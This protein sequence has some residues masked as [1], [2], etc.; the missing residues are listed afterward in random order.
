MLKTFEVIRDRPDVRGL[1]LGHIGGDVKVAKASVKAQ[2][3]ARATMTATFVSDPNFL[4]GAPDRER[5]AE[6][7]AQA[8]MG[9]VNGLAALGV[10]QNLSPEELTDLLM[11]LL[12]PGIYAIAEGR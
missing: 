11:A 6:H 9:T 10:E 7:V 3:S 1:L 5:R 8:V 4:A 12:W 2:R